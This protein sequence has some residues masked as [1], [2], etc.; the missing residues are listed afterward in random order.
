MLKT[1]KDY[2]NEKLPPVIRYCHF[3]I[4]FLVIA[5]I[6]ISEFIHV[7]KA[8]KLEQ[9]GITYFATWTHIGIGLFMVAIASIFT[10]IE[11]RKHGF[12]YFFPYLFG[13]FEQIKSDIRA[14][15]HFNLPEATAKG[16]AA[17]V[18]GLGI[19][20]LLLVVFSGLAWFILWQSGS[21]FAH[22]IAELH[23][24]LT[25][26]I[27]AYIIAHG[28]LGILHIYHAYKKTA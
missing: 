9:Q 11:L 4:I 6:L 3:L 1:I 15:T 20:A 24:L 14:L 26:L 5:Q 12:A 7:D 28:A 17:T 19:G 18:Q 22:E 8:G 2:F 25:G 10:I 21:P 27:E 23:E 13:D 16:L